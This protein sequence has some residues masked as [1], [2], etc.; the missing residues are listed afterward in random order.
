MKL[1]PDP[2]SRASMLMGGGIALTTT[3]VGSV[4]SATQTVVFLLGMLALVA[5]LAYSQARASGTGNKE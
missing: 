2:Q 5:S 3:A 4:L 1:L